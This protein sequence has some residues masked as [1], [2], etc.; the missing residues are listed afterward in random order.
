MPIGK[1]FHL[2]HV[3]D[4]LAAADDFYDRVFA[5]TTERITGD[6]RV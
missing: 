6:P 3:V 4:D 5:F 1:F 2:I